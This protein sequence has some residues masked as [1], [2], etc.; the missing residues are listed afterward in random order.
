MNILLEVFNK[1]LYQPLF[2]ALVLIYNYFPGNDFGIAVI[3]LT[4]LIRIALHPLMSQSLKSQRVMSE[5]QPKIK[6]VQKKFKD[7]KQKQTEELLKIYQEAK[8]NPISGFLPLLIQLPLLIALYQVFWK[9]LEP[10][11]MSSLYAFVPNAGIINPSFLGLVNL[12]QASMLLAILAGT[13]QFFQAKSMNPKMKKAGDNKANQ[14][15]NIMQKQMMY[16]LP[17]FTVMILLRLPAAIALYWIAT[18]SFSIM[19][20]YFV[21]KNYVES[22]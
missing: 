21:N 9:G 19:Q 5:L 3:V 7:D 4:V 2:N 1:V 18:S 20:Q 12:S 17:F 14:I 8:I 15:A 6:E 16:F 22:Q 11:A 13:L 10:G